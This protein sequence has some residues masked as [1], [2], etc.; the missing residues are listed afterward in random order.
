MKNI[1][2]L[3]IL[4]LISCSENSQKISRNEIYYIEKDKETGWF[5][6]LNTKNKWG[7]IDK[8][9]IIKIPFE[10]DFVNPFEHQL[11]Y[12]KNKGKE[13]YINPKNEIVIE[14]RFD[15]I[16]IFSEGLASVKKDGK[17]GFINEKGKLIIPLIY[18][19]VDY[20]R[21]SGLCAVT[22]NGKSGF[23]DK[24]GKEII[25][26][27]YPEVHQEMFD[28]IVIVKNNRK[29]AFFDNH[30]NQLS[31]FIYDKVFRTDYYDFSKD[32]FTRDQ[33]TF[34]KNGAALVLKN[35]KYEFLNEKIKP[36]FVNNKFDSASVFDA[37]KNAIVKRNGKYGMIKPS[38]EFKVPFKFDFIEPYDTAH[39]NYSEYY[40][41][42][43][44]KIYSF[45]NKNLKKIGESYEPIYNNFSTDN[46]Q[47]SFKNLKGK[48]GVVDWQ[49]NEKIPFVYDEA[50][51]FK[52]SKNCIAKK[53]GKFGV[54]SYQN[55]EIFP[56][57]YDE[58]NELDEV[59]N[60][61]NTYLLSNKKED[62]IV[63]INGKTFLSGYQMI[64][65]IFYDHSKFIVKKNNKFGIA[66]LQN[67]IL[68]PIVFDEISDWVE[69]GPEDRHIVKRNGKYGMVEYKTFKE[70]IPAI[71][72]FV[73]IAR[74][75]VFVGKDEK[76]GI[77]DLNNKIICPLT[78]DEIK[79]SFGYG[80]GM[81]ESRIFARK[82]KQYLEIDEKGKVL[83]EISQKLYKEN[84]D[85]NFDQI[86]EPPKAPRIN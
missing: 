36:A 28:R 48:Y 69:Y 58:I 33:S 38:G 2:Y 76:Y 81:S 3:L 59:E 51:D 35:G 71:Y 72:D 21:T 55:K 31:D 79:P 66:D 75:K 6:V 7:F 80:F 65:P 52:R 53:N 62:K 73:F 85:R 16:D 1:I 44:G 15:K 60:L 11:A 84:T 54:I 74:D 10:Y 40:N 37:F 64:H 20:F 4:F 22:L 26:I 17:F 83:K 5:R 49:G 30:G 18:D 86:P 70:K 25:K 82:G 43:K 8:D 39:G 27:I 50:L 9:S 14:G 47:I 77:I 57:I 32:I 19:N 61:K 23:I 78:Y 68:L 45:F 63:N 12:V 46:P 42:R 67:K 13:F 24:S 29:W 34:F 56:F 41:A